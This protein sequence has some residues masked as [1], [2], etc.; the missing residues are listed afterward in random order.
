MTLG[1]RLDSRKL[2][3]AK[4]PC[5]RTFD[6]KDVTPEE[7]QA[8][9]SYERKEIN[10]DFLMHHSFAPPKG[11]TSA[12]LPGDLGYDPERDR[13]SLMLSGASA[14]LGHSVTR[15]N[16][17]L[18]VLAV[19]LQGCEVT[20]LR[21]LA[22]LPECQ[23]LNLSDNE[24]GSLEWLP[25]M[26]KLQSL[27]L[28]RCNLTSLKGL[29]RCQELQKLEAAGNH[30]TDALELQKLSKLSEVSLEDNFVDSLDTFASLTS[31][32][33]LYLSNNVI[34]DLR[35]VLLLK[36]L[37][38]LMVLE[39]SGNDLCKV[40]DYRQYTMFHLRKMK[41]LDGQ[42]ISKAEQHQAD[43]KFSGKVTMEL[44]EDKLGPSPS[45]YTFRTVDLSGQ[46]IRELGTLLNDDLFPSL[47]ELVLDGNPFSDI[48][49]VGPLS[50]L[51]VLRMN[52]SKLDL[53]NGVT[54]TAAPAE[55][56]GGLSTLPNLQVMEIGYSG[57]SDMRFFAQFPLQTLRILHLPGNDIS[58]L[59]GLNHMEQLRELVVDKNKIKQFDEKS[60]EG[61]RS[62]RELRAE[63][64]GLKS[65]LNLGPLP[66]LRALY[67]SVNRIAELSELDRLRHLRHLLV[68][69]M[70]QNP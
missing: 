63:D 12:R 48:R 7:A 54:D 39:L 57:I 11:S 27:S 19:D 2:A 28:E 29:G 30:L 58:K 43:E 46:G 60:F 36:Q 66:R 49:T 9:R 22:N 31:L 16:W 34:E 68:V 1:N 45:C 62:L 25:E 15:A 64:N 6:G 44:L 8:Y 65:L 51:L 18:K 26:P 67:L 59:E 32:M 4:L 14:Q 38:K 5:L 42:P 56:H 47:R 37:P 10:E 53:E 24:L 52:K 70:A 40:A 3:V 50:K 41:V 21:F 20:E 13:V 35:S 69:H 55:F 61:L 33:E 17:R 23:T